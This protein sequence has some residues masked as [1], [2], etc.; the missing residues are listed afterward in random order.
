MTGADR[1]LAD[2]VQLAH[3]G[4]FG[5]HVHRLGQQVLPARNSVDVTRG[6]ELLRSGRVG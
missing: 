1:V 3:A 2:A 5:R 4:V 6:Y